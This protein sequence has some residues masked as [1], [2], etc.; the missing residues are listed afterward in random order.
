[1]TEEKAMLAK[2]PAPDAMAVLAPAKP[3]V[4]CARS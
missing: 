3:A 4:K 1:V 2:Q